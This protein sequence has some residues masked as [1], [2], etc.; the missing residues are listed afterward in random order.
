MTKR[1]ISR[2]I[3]LALGPAIHAYD[4]AG[5]A[6]KHEFA[7]LGKKVARALAALMGLEQ[8]SYEVRYN[9]AGIA[10]CGDIHLHGEYVY[11]A[12]E[13]NCLGGSHGFMYRFCK[14]RKDY[15]GGPNQWMKFE[16]LADLEEAAS[17]IK[18]HC[19]AMKERVANS[20]G[21]F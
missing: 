8:G 11:V 19:L 10:V 4:A 7:R 5:E 21:H 9:K 17:T 6:R 3:E 20:T 15:T 1:E 12:L 18:S 16:S 14:G 2:F 13:Q